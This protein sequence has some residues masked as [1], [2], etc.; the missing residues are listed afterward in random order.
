MEYVVGYQFDY[1]P[2]SSTALVKEH[3]LNSSSEYV[4]ILEMIWHNGVRLM[5][6]KACQVS[7]V[8]FV[9]HRTLPFQGE[10]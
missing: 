10:S 7:D 5:L 9:L 2:S 4:I 1:G 8:T 6:V 3:V